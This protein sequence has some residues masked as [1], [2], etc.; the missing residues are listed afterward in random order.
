[1]GWAGHAVEPHGQGGVRARLRD[2][3][4][5]TTTTATT[6]TTTTTTKL[7]LLPH[8]PNPNP[9][10]NPNHYYRRCPWAPRLMASSSLAAVASRTLP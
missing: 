9:N 1:M 8:N 7:L 10:P 6:A 3:G 4:A 2:T 5:V